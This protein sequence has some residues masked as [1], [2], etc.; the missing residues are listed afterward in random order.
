MRLKDFDGDPSEVLELLALMECLK[1]VRE[2]EMSD[3]EHNNLDSELRPHT[4]M[5]MDQ[6]VVEDLAMNSESYFHE[7]TLNDV[8][9]LLFDLFHNLVIELGHN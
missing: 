9:Q 4:T 3:H 2:C 1:L 7:P 8:E 5:A 6:A